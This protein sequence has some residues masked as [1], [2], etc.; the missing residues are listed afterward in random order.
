[1]P[2]PLDEVLD[3]ANAVEAIVGPSPATDVP[4]GTLLEV[5]RRLR[6]LERRVDELERRADGGV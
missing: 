2:D 3:R 5:T 6:A 4:Y 1:M